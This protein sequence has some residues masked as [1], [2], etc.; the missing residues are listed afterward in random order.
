MRKSDDFPT[1]S[2]GR[3]EAGEAQIAAQAVSPTTRLAACAVAAHLRVV[4]GRGGVAK[5]RETQVAAGRRLGCRIATKCLSGELKR[6]KE[7]GSEPIGM[8]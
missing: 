6:A 4:R 8:Y 3:R 2:R 7:G 5:C 1:P